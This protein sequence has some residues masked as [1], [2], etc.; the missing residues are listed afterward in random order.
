MARPKARELTERELEIMQVFWNRGDSTAQQVRDELA[1]GGHELAYT[2][3]A[4]L[5]RILTDKGFLKQIESSRPFVYAPSQSFSDV[6]R[7]L[8]TD[9]IDRVFRG[10]P[11]QLL[12]QL[13][14][15]QDLSDADRESIS[16]IL[17]EN[18]Q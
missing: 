18:N 11:T 15:E 12:L 9:L 16:R 10:S 17:T 6:S 1:A 4:T 3:V 2:T 5:I 13:M 7:R 8:V 14:E